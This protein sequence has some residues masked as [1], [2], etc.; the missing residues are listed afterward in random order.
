MRLMPRRGAAEVRSAA[1]EGGFSLLEAVIAAAL[2]L[3]TVSAV[4]I[5][6]NCA[7]RAGGHADAAMRADRA[8]GSVAAWLQALP[9]CAADAPTAATGRGRTALDLVSAVFPHACSWMDAPDARFVTVDEDGAK[10]GSFVTR[11]SED[12]IAVVCVARYCDRDGV[13][14]AAASV[15]GFDVATSSAV[16]GPQLELALYARGAGGTRSCRLMRLAGATAD[17]DPAEDPE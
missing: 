13:S 6:V 17:V 9:Y 3:L 7:S 11:L 1:P 16:P 2:L 4:T 8:L 5:Y 14:L 12:G 10:S 15:D